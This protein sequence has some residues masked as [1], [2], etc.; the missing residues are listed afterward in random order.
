MPVNWKSI[1]LDNNNHY[2]HTTCTH[3]IDKIIN[4]QSKICII[5]YTY[6]VQVPINVF[7]KRGTCFNS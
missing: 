4:I 6:I 2:N 3:S 1:L 5:M 7:N